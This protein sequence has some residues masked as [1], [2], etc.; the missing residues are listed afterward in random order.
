MEQLQIMSIRLSHIRIEM[1][2]HAG[3]YTAVE[4]EVK[5]AEDPD[6][7][8]N[9]PNRLL[10]WTG[11]KLNSRPNERQSRVLLRDQDGHPFNS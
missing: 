1:I 6:N 9:V 10:S 7:K 5:M 4:P 8:K 3:F 11:G 2:W